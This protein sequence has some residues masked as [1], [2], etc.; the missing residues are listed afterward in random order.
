MRTYINMPRS[1]GPVNVYFSYK[2]HRLWITLGILFFSPLDFQFSI[3]LFLERVYVLEPF[4]Y[5]PPFY[6][7][8]FVNIVI[9]YGGKG[10]CSNLL[11]VFSWACLGDLDY[12]VFLLLLQG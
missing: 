11:I 5:N 8:K 6:F 3:V 2:H 1:L 4:F 9:D 7:W 12:E 10:V